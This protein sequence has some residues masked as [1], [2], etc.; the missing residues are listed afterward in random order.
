MPT[1]QETNE[2]HERLS[3]FFK[4]IHD[5]LR[6]LATRK[7]DPKGGTLFPSELELLIEGAWAE[8]DGDFDLDGALTKIA[9]L[10]AADLGAHGL[11]GKQLVLKLRVIE[12]WQQRFQQFGGRKVF[13]KLID[14]ID[15]L[16]ESLLEAAGLDGAIKELKDI[17][18]DSVDEDE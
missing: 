4:Q 17:L 13:K 14:A 8:F 10:S 9:G 6:D 1:A 15:T 5:F 3:E 12:I 11:Y 18:S 2:A 7:H 16:L